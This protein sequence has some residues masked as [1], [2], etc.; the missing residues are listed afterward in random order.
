MVTQI[1]HASYKV[2]RGFDRLVVIN[3]ARM[4]GTMHAGADR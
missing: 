4:L 3:N 2:G 1:K